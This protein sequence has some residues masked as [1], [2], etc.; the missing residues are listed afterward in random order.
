MP[1]QFDSYSLAQLNRLKIF[2]IANNNLFGLVSADLVS[3]DIL[4]FDCN[5]KFRKK[6]LGSKCG[7]LSSKSLAIIVAASVVGAAASLFIGFVIWWWFFIKS[8]S[9]K[10]KS[11]GFGNGGG[12]KGDSS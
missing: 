1:L 6:P 4:D 8:S 3:F 7:G 9:G 11:Y 5:D 10:G 12:F 2:S